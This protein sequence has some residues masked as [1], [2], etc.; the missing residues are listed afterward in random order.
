MTKDEYK[1]ERELCEIVRK[2]TTAEM[3]F[4]RGGRFH[5]RVLKMG[6]NSCDGIDM[7]E[8]RMGIAVEQ[9]HSDDERVRAKIG[10]DHIDE[11]KDYYTRLAKMEAECEWHG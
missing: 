9:E 7:A 4:Y 6:K 3:G 2:F 8:L 11:C 1:R 10:L 5:D